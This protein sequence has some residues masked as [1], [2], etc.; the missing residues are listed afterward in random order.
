M[1]AN[2]SGHSSF[3]NLWLV[4]L[5]LLTLPAANAQVT[6]SVSKGIFGE[7]VLGESGNNVVLVNSTGLKITRV[8][9]GE[10]TYEDIANKQDR[11]FINVSPKRHN[12]EV[13]FRGGAHID[14]PHFSFYNV[15][16]IVFT[17]SGN[18]VVANP[19]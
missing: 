2:G 11:V 9:I 13:Y 10:R 5:L 7:G 19:R 6:Q 15:R 16:E 18:H 4:L 14:W 1:T 17:L 8:V 12:M 3:G